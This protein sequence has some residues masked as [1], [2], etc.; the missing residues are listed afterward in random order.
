METDPDGQQPEKV[1]ATQ[2]FLYQKWYSTFC[3]CWF[4]DSVMCPVQ[5]RGLPVGFLLDLQSRRA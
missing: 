1:K 4:S 5:F 2:I 3:P